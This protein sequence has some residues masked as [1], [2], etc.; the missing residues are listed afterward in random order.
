MI[1]SL[2]LL[3]ILQIIVCLTMFFTFFK[4]IPWLLAEPIANVER[5]PESKEK[6]LPP[7]WAKSF[8][9]GPGGIAY[10]SDYHAEE[11][12]KTFTFISLIAGQWVFL[13]AS[14]IYAL[15]IRHNA[16]RKDAITSSFKK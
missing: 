16:S 2:K 10:Y 12:R 1:H 7:T 13:V 15:K 11:R 4:T 6:D 8:S 9:A 14:A 5:Y 3:S